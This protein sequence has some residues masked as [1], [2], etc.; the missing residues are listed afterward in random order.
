MR[1]A[2]VRTKMIFPR[3]RSELV[4]RPRLSEELSR[5][6]DAALILVSAPAGFGKT[7]LVAAALDDGAPV[8]WVSLDARDGDG[9]RVWTRSSRVW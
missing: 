3:L 4:S 1:F 2:L 5:A 9:R 7:T 6:E 8:A